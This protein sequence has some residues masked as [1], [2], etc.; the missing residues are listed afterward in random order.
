LGRHDLG[1]ALGGEPLLTHGNAVFRLAGG[2]DDADLRAA[3]RACPLPGWV[4]I[5]FEREP[6]Y[7]GAC[8]VEGS[9]AQ[10]V[11][12]RHRNT[13]ELIGFFSRSCR[14]A[15]VA[16]DRVRLG[17][18]GQLRLAP[19]WQTRSRAILRGFEVCRDLLADGRQDTPYFLTSI[20]AG[21]ARALRML[22]SGSR[23]M[24]TYRPMADY[25]TLALSSAQRL[26]A[27]LPPGYALERGSRDS[28][29]EIARFLLDQ[30]RRRTFSPAWTLAE[31]QRLERCA[32]APEDFLLLRRGGVPIACLALW[33]QRQ[34]KQ[35]RITGYS[36]PLAILRPL[37]APALKAITYPPL[38][39]AGS[40]LRQ[41]FI[42]HVEVAEDGE[43]VFLALMA[44][45]LEDARNQGIEILTIGFCAAHPLL[46]VAQKR[47]RG[48]SYCSR[49]Y[50]VHWPEGESEAKRL[51]GL[52][53][54]AEVALL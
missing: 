16:G 20:L 35:A 5:A 45:A 1:G 25:V 40:I 39:A 54:H 4:S 14:E 49:L 26:S 37:A 33:D 23:G 18:L 13:G 15:F 51:E 12:A 46:A 29:P 8:E 22:T 50:L 42:S 41:A 31:L 32:L 21:N 52:P 10:V 6:S 48:L 44:A 9:F 38:P 36:R 47:L 17:Y 27:P 11:V 28:L 53:I 34:F 2:A 24:P 19:A 3:L 43:A 7:F 30:A